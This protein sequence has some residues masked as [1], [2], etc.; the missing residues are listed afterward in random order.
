[1]AFS[2]SAPSA[3]LTEEEESVLRKSCAA[4]KTGAV[5][6]SGKKRCTFWKTSRILKFALPGLSLIDT[7]GTQRGPTSVVL[8]TDRGS[9]SLPGS[10]TFMN[11]PANLSQNSISIF[12]TVRTERAPSVVGRVQGPPKLP[13]WHL[14]R[15]LP[16]LRAT[17]SPM[18]SVF[19]YLSRF[20]CPNTGAEPRYL[21][22]RH[23][24]SFGARDLS[25]AY[26]DTV[27]TYQLV[28]RQL[29]PPAPP[30]L[31]SPHTRK[32]GISAAGGGH[33]PSLLAAHR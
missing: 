4:E 6:R 7:R 27:G 9:L 2:K 26:K 24:Y 23:P 33:R 12:E 14:P 1:M 32:P 16:F 11:Q 18:L 25:F 17:V 8:G 20:Y 28:C 30:G 13:L 5:W 19:Y 22:N 31:G 21:S 10:R 15:Y 3:Y 29:E